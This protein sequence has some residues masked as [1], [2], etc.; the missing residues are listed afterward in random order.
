MASRFWELV[1]NTNAIHLLY[2]LDPVLLF[3][4]L[5]VRHQRLNDIF[6]RWSWNHIQSA[7]DY[8]ILP[9]RSGK[10]VVIVKSVKS[11][12]FCSSVLGLLNAGNH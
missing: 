2:D 1:A 5:N 4:R 10:R 3:L 9:E 11:K 8:R 7:T 12:V 6:V